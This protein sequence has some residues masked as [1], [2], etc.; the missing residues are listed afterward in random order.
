MRRWGA[1]VLVVTLGWLLSPTAVPVYD[2]VGFPDQPYRYLGATPAPSVMSATAQAPGG[3]STALQ[4]QSAESGPQV[5]VDVAAGTFRQPDAGAVTLTATPVA[6]GIPP[7]DGALD[8]NVYRVTAG[9]ATVQAAQAQGFLYLRAAVMTK[10][11]PVVE[12]R[13]TPTATWM[14]LPTTRVGTDILGVPF[15]AV[16]DYVVVRLPGSTPLSSAGGISGTR[17]ALLAGGLLLLLVIIVAV[18]RRPREQD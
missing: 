12:F 3:T 11:S 14:R 16:G 15:R 7:V 10:P 8:G 17:I 13:P 1:A 4:G 9:P 18:V 2:G 5:K 6:A